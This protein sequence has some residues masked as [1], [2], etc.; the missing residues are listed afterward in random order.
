MSDSP[1]TPLSDVL[2]L[3]R[4]EV[5]IEP[6]R[7]YETA[8]IYSFGR[9]LFPRG[10][11]LGAE[12]SYKVLF[13]LHKD[14][15]VIS[16][17]NGWEGAVDVVPEA[18]HG[19][20]V[21]N[22]YPTFLVRRDRADPNYL[23]WIARWPGLWERLIPRGSM[24]RRKRVQPSQ[25]L[26]VEIPLPPLREQTQIA[27]RLDAIRREVSR[28]ERAQIAA[29]S[30]SEG[31]ADAAVWN[32][33]RRGM[34]AGWSISPL[35]EVAEVNPRRDRLPPGQRVGWVPM[36]AVDERSGTISL[37]EREVGDIRS[38]YRQFRNGDVVFA[39]ITPCMQNGKC[40]ILTGS[41]SHAYGSTEF[42]V[43]RPQQSTHGRWIHRFLRTKEIRM[44]ATKYFTGTAGQQRVP[45]DYLRH[46]EIPFPPEADQIKA[47]R[48]IDRIVE[49]GATLSEG[50]T[51]AAELRRAVEPAV[52]NQAFSPRKR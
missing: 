5:H 15:F 50:R 20:L 8:G 48:K 34:E 18:L 1:L 47:L 31:L 21:S 6:D 44:R 10:P 11:I 39:R 45:A 14:Q 2:V 36:A 17:L 16:R 42:H 23:K 38:G 24:V 25:L 35:G 40:A 9:G 46:L 52:L 26:E 22:E 37:E 19:S 32:V 28:V 7:T 3:D 33:F 4:D 30:L 49:I 41:V 27:E 51:R 13:R 43:V 29:T 12:T